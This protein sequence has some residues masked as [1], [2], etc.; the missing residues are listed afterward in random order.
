MVIDLVQS[1]S[2]RIINLYR[3][4]TP[5]NGLIE[6]ANFAVQL[7]LIAAA[8]NSNTST[9]RGRFHKLIYALPPAVCAPRPIFEKLFTGAKVGRKAQKIGVG[10][11]TV[12]EINHQEKT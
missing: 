12:Y 8:W 11:K 6:R 4:F 1:G 2:T 10:R 7:G 9:A 3:Q 5:V